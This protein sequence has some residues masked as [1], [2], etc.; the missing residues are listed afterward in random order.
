MAAAFE[1]LDDFLDDYL[2]LPVR[3]RDG[4]VR[5]YRIAS[6]PAEDGL[7][8]EKITRAAARMLQDGTEPD[9]ESLSDAEERDLYRM[10]L[11]DVHDQL[12]ADTDWSRFKHAALTA[13]F[14]V[15][16]DCETAQKYWAS[17][18]DPSRVAPNRAARRQQ[19]RANSASAAASTTRS[20]GSTNGTR[21]A[22]PRSGKAK[23]AARK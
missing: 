17:G 3:G 14:W 13:M 11:G 6:P 10:L 9:A 21:A 22:S 12:L 19:T 4:E 2:E 23:A 8:V 7:R 16:A 20:R 1:A 5:T 18:G 15:T